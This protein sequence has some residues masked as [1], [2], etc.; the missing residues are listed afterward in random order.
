[1]KKDNDDGLIKL[2]EVCKIL[3]VHP[4]T[5]RAWDKKGILKAVRFGQRGDRRY[6]KEDIMNLVSKSK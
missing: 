5:L 2:S 1:M 6:R 4:Q 3:N